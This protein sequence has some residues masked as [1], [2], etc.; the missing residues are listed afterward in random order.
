MNTNAEKEKYSHKTSRFYLSAL[1]AVL[2]VALAILLLQDPILVLYYFVS[3]LFITVTTIMLRI[4]L[5]SIGTQKQPGDNLSQTEE[6]HSSFG[7]LIV[8]FLALLAF[9]L[10][11]LLLAKLLNPY[12]WF[13]LMISLT[14]GLSIA[15]MLFYFHT[16]RNLVKNSKGIRDA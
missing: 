15:E 11:P 12:S 5:F 10:L 14:S 1:T 6:N 3:T 7:I 13:I 16:Q 8:M 4:R 9:L 2:S